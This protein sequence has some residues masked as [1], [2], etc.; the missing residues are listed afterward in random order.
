MLRN[1]HDARF[2]DSFNI[3]SAQLVCMR[4]AEVAELKAK[5]K[6]SESE[7]TKVEELRKCVSDLEGTF[8]VKVGEAASLTA[9]NVSLL[10]NVS[11]LE[12]EHDGLK[13]PN[14]G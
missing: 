11:A 8:A 12:L 10:E 1:Q 13:G 5:L 4:D 2:L 7:A 6:K 9:Q 14:Y 3:N